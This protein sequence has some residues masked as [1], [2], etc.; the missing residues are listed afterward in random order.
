MHFPLFVRSWED[1]GVLWD[2]YFLF[3]SFFLFGF[4]LGGVGGGGFGAEGMIEGSWGV[5]VQSLTKSASSRT[6]KLAPFGQL[7][8]GSHHVSTDM[9]QVILS[10]FPILRYKELKKQV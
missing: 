10:Q 4:F 3:L 8:T 2:R 9:F 5:F 1:L 6:H 7:N